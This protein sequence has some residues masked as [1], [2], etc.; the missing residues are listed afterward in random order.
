MCHY[1]MALLFFPHGNWYSPT[2]A[3]SSSKVP[4]GFLIGAGFQENSEKNLWLSRISDSSQA[5]LFLSLA[6]QPHTA[7]PLSRE[8]LRSLGS[9][10]ADQNKEAWSPFMAKPG[11]STQ[12]C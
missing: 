10:G 12:S 5:P 3:N 8:L 6:L 11:V 7:H 4:R 2:S 9:L 1:V